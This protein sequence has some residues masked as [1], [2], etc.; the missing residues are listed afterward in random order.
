MVKVGDAAPAFT[1]KT[2]DKS[3][4]NL[5]DYHGKNVILAFYPG[6]FTG[7]CDKEICTFQDNFSRLSES[8]T[9][10]LGISVDFPMGEC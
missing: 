4:V 3:D 6:A 1:L 9:V 7:V 5:A 10:V 2:T 8:G